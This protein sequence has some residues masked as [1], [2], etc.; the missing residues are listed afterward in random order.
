MSQGCEEKTEI[1]NVKLEKREEGRRKIRNPKSEIR[2]EGTVNC[3][4]SVLL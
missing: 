2:K 4:P 3:I 1:R